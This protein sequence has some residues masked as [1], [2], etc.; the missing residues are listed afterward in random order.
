MSDTCLDKHEYK[1][2][3]IEIH[4]DDTPNDPRDWDNMGTLLMNGRNTGRIWEEPC[5]SQRSLDDESYGGDDDWGW[6]LVIREVIEDLDARVIL[7]FEYID[8]G[9]NG[10]ALKPRGQTL[11]VAKGRVPHRDV[12]REQYDRISGIMYVTHD[13]LGEEYGTQRIS[14]SIMDRA[15]LCLRGELATMSLYFNNAC[16]GYIVKNEYGTNL[17][18]CW[19]LYSYDDG[20]YDDGMTFA[21]A[22]A[23]LAADA[24]EIT[25]E[26]MQAARTGLAQVVNALDGGTLF[27]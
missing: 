18:A 24:L 19:G 9:S 16:Y 1:G 25:P 23:K 20:Y 8:Y 26:M 6:P 11:T 15:L 14:K 17:D 7:P 3:T 5:I 10:C 2:F 12:L 13:K 21:L 22:E 27:V 4:Y